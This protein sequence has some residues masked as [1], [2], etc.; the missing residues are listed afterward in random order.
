MQE[1][2]KI[3]HLRQEVELLQK[4]VSEFRLHADFGLA[5]QTLSHNI[6]NSIGGI[7]ASLEFQQM[8]IDQ[9]VSDV[10]SSDEVSKIDLLQNL[11][12]IHRFADLA[13]SAGENLSK[14][15]KQVLVKTQAD[16]SFYTEKFD[17]S[18]L[19]LMEANFLKY[20]APFTSA[21]IKLEVN[22]LDTEILISARKHDI[23]QVIE[24]LLHNAVEAIVG[25]G[26]IIVNVSLKH[27]NCHFEVRDTGS[28]IEK[29]KIKEIFNAFYSTKK[30]END[31]QKSIFFGGTG[32][33]LYSCEKIIK[34]YGGKII[35]DGALNPGS[36]FTVILPLS[37]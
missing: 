22:V 21:E 6:K 20:T 34:E 18:K 10:S 24:N 8:L 29:S 4:V 9:L 28:G 26:T 12:E 3:K 31:S 17:V 15:V 11:A 7:G 36:S 14:Q 30:I 2:E 16:H 27:G 1:S 32:L 33:G 35:V 23:V 5:F 37:N 25:K 19:V 13:Y